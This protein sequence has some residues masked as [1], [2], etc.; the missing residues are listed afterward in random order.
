MPDD[1]KELIEVNKKSMDK[2]IAKC[3]PGVRFYRIGEAIEYVNGLRLLNAFSG[4]TPIAK[5]TW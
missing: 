4:T 2:A 3:G 5:V 1:I